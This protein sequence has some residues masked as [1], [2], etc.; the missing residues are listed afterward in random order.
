MRLGSELSVAAGEKQCREVRSQT[1][2]EYQKT[3]G[4]RLQPRY[5][6]QAK[7]EYEGSV[8]TEIPRSLTQCKKDANY[9]KWHESK[10]EVGVRVHHAS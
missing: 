1:S 9:G 7:G 4:Q 5:T 6:K 10:K 8:Q 3:L 2:T